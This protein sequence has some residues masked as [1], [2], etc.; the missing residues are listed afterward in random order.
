MTEG[1]FDFVI[2]DF[3][4]ETLRA[5]F[6]LLTDRCLWQWLREFEPGPSDFSKSTDIQ[7]TALR[8]YFFYDLIAEHGINQAL[9][10]MQYIAQHGWSKYRIHYK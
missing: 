10:H 6:Q 8:S 3:K 2:D 5:A 4:R 7:M 9:R 1:D